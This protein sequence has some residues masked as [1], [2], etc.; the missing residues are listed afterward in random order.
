MKLFSVTGPLLGNS[1][2]KTASNQGIGQGVRPSLREFKLVT[3]SEEK[4][5]VVVFSEEGDENI[6]E[7]FSLKC[8]KLKQQC[9]SITA[10]KM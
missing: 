8:I 6:F 1:G 2:K 5:S 4:T 10:R 3:L 9:I 7:L